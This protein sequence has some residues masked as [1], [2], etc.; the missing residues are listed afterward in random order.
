[1]MDCQFL[2]RLVDNKHKKNKNIKKILRDKKA[3][4]QS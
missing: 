1:M 3:Y 2:G 4:K